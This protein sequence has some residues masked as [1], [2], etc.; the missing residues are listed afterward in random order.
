VYR[1]A[2]D[3]LYEQLKAGEFCYVFNSRQMGKSSLRLQVVQRLSAANISC[4]AVDLSSFTFKD[5]SA[6]RWY[7]E[8]IKALHNYQAFELSNQVNLNDWF[9]QHK[10]SS[11]VTLLQEYIEDVLLVHMP[12]E[13]VIILIDETDSVLILDFDFSDF[14]AFIRACYNKAKSGEATAYERLTFALFGVA[15]PPLLIRDKRRTPFNIGAAIAL[16]GLKFEHAKTLAEGFSEWVSNPHAMLKAILDWTGGQPFLTQKLCKLVQEATRELPSPLEAGQETAWLEELVRSRIITNWQFQDEPEHLRTIRNR[17]LQ[18]EGG[19]QKAWRLLSLYQEILYRG[20]IDAD[21]SD[22]QM[23]LRL[24]GLVVRQQGKLQVY[25][26]LYKKVFNRDWV[27][28]ALADLCPYAEDLAAWE[29]SDRKNES[30]LLRG[31]RL[32][33]GWNWANQQKKASPSHNSFLTA[34]QELENHVQQERSL[35]LEKANIEAQQKIAEAN[36]R[37]EEAKHQAQQQLE[38]ARQ[39]AQQKINQ[40]NLE[41]QRKVNRANKL[42][43]LGGLV[44]LL[45]IAASIL[46]SIYQITDSNQKVSQVKKETDRSQKLYQVRLHRLEGELRDA[47]SLLRSS[48]KEYKDDLDFR[49]EEAALLIWS[50]PIQKIE[51]REGRIRIP[52]PIQKELENKDTENCNEAIRI[53]NS[54]LPQKPDHEA[55]KKYRVEA[56]RRGCSIVEESGANSRS[57]SSF[58]TLETLTPLPNQLQFL[59]YSWN[60]QPT[61]LQNN[62]SP[63]NQV[64]QVTSLA[65]NQLMV[66]EKQNVQ[67]LYSQASND[68]PMRIQADPRN[69]R[70]MAIIVPDVDTTRSAYGGR[71][72]LYDVHI[73]K[74]FEVTHFL[75]QRDPKL[76]WLQW[77]YTAN[78][79]G[80]YMGTF[81]IKCSEAKRLAEIYGLD[82]PESTV[83]KNYAQ[84]KAQK[85][86]ILKLFAGQTARTGQ[87]KVDSWISFTQKNFKPIPRRSYVMPFTPRY[88]I[89]LQPEKPPLL[90]LLIVAPLETPKASD[91][92]WGR[93]MEMSDVSIRWR[94]VLLSPISAYCEMSI[95]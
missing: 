47:D 91:S 80:T 78:S 93:G 76:S 87:D 75:C 48:L 74:M 20:A 13:K 84:G 60:E 15:T 44:S 37:L 7:Q 55:A 79:G 94:E 65:N 89:T 73:A 50:I 95:T 52:S 67:Q 35:L 1:K 27:K 8:L 66:S 68:L 71:L 22:D 88:Y 39:E 24:S 16:D 43:L 53:L 56:K 28:H 23:E 51:D 62:L 42:L 69:K 9:E 17:I 77:R 5:I 40:A 11:Q 85:I 54:V 38:D 70:K 26:R 57:I 45:L 3:D 18:G 49:A 19:E 59:A 34:S 86:S 21:D 4:T 31:Q 30:W 46:F 82:K 72:R 90:S 10:N 2:D 61:K 81:D 33:D 25:N 92:Y 36:Q 29:V 32:K 14:F 63:S 64:I 6:E 83:I 12:G 58:S 41:V